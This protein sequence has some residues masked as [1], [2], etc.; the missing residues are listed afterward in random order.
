MRVCAKAASGHAH[1]LTWLQHHEHEVRE[2]L[3]AQQ[4]IS[5]VVIN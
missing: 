4:S 5:C 3:P 1:M 2:G